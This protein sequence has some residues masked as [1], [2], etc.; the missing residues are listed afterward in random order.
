MPL[1]SIEVVAVPI[2]IQ[3]N[4]YFDLIYMYGNNKYFF[5][6]LVF[7]LAFCLENISNYMR[8]FLYFVLAFSPRLNYYFPFLSNYFKSKQSSV[9]T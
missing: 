4:K 7:F 6:F 9:G 5:A 2:F 3:A 1:S 8:I